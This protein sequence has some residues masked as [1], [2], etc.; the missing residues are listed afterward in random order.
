M[1]S[2]ACPINVLRVLATNVCNHCCAFC[3][4]EG[5]GA[6]APEYLDP[7]A[8]SNVVSASYT[9]GIRQIQFSGGEPASHPDFGELVRIARAV[10]P[11][12][13]LGVATNGSLF[14]PALMAYIAPIMANIRVN[15]GG[16]TDHR[17]RLRTGG[18]DLERVLDVIETLADLKAN[19]G[20]NT[21]LFDQTFEEILELIEFTAARSIDLKILEWINPSNWATAPRA[22]DLCKRLSATAHRNEYLSQSVQR[23]EVPIGGRVGR[24][25]VVVT[26]CRT[27]LSSA[28]REYGEVR[29]LPNLGLQSCVMFGSKTVP[30][31]RTEPAHV[32]EAL[33]YAAAGIG[34]CFLGTG[35]ALASPPTT[36]S[37]RKRHEP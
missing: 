37:S 23:F 28:C 21:V 16:L 18:G 22:L 12:A 9:Y 17:H 19:V 13:R 7:G 33:E 5:Q 14:T 20:V 8:F 31:R 29:L 11:D 34:E 30:I 26:P 2:K 1:R 24:V 3:H 32:A 27:N 6:G 25:R 36:A 15:L 35:S 4:N 10:A